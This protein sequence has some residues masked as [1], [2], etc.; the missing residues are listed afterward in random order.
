MS[1]GGDML[2]GLPAD[3]LALGLTKAYHDANAGNAEARALVAEIVQAARQ[4]DARAIAAKK[5]LARIDMQARHVP[6]ARGAGAPTFGARPPGAVHRPGFGAGPR[7]QIAMGMRLAPGVFGG[8]PLT[9]D[10]E[11]QLIAFLDEAAARVPQAAQGGT[12][13][14]AAP[15]GGGDGGIM[16]ALKKAH[17]KMNTDAQL[18]LAKLSASPT[19]LRQILTGPNWSQTQAINMAADYGND[20]VGPAPT[21]APG[22]INPY[23]Q[24]PGISLSNQDLWYQ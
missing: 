18:A 19:Q 2:L 8:V 20:G 17:Q 24:G 5:A 23:A 10:Q 9:L 7:A 12:E 15:G 14:S 16:E 22:T 6:V 3:K 11:D 4:G 13:G 1:T 21:N